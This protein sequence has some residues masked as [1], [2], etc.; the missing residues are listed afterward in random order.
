[1][2]FSIAPALPAISPAMPPAAFAQ[3][4]AGEKR[5]SAGSHGFVG[6]PHARGDLKNRPIDANGVQTRSKYGHAAARKT[7][8]A[9][10]PSA[11]VPVPEHLQGSYGIAE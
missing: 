2:R 9:Q 3:R 6:S 4:A 8:A 7:E 1:M 11:D 10:R 5:G